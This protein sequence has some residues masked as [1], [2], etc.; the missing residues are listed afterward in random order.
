MPHRLIFGY[1]G[2]NWVG[3][4]IRPYLQ[5]ESSAVEAK[6]DEIFVYP[7]PLWRN[8]GSWGTLGGW[9]LGPHASPADGDGDIVFTR[10]IIEY[11]KE[12]YCIDG[13]RIFATG[14]SWGGDMSEILACFAD[15]DFRATAPVAA[16]RP[17]WFEPSPGDFIDCHGDTAMWVLFGVDDDHFAGSQ[18]YP[19]EFGDDQRDYW[20]DTY[21]CDGEDAFSDLGFGGSNECVE[22]SGCSP[23]L[24][25][26][27]YDG[28]YGHQIPKDYFARAVMEFFRSF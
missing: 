22:Y 8:F 3:D 12:N 15:D 5:L 27:L 13:D 11:M 17:Y 19:G 20:L 28:K 6:D 14:H 18:S 1:A 21:G 4:K 7:D 10:K 2:T 23:A 16:N 25:Y 24:R 26:C 9:V